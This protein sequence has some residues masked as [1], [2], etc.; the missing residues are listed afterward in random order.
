MAHYYNIY[1]HLK[2]GVNERFKENRKILVGK[3]W[4]RKLYISSTNHEGKHEGKRT[5]CIFTKA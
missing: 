2:S 5:T 3:R 4:K 1:S